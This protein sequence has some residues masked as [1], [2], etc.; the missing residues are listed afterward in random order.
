MFNFLKSKP[1]SDEELQAK[2]K[3]L[4]DTCMAKG[5]MDF[6]DSDEYKDLL[7]KIYLRK[8]TPCMILESKKK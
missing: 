6:I 4:C 8:L 5:Y 1:V 3:A 7:E 2:L